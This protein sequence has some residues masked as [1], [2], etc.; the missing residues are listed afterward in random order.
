MQLNFTLWRPLVFLQAE[1]QAQLFYGA[2]FGL[3]AVMA[4]YNLFLFFAV[5]LR[6]YLFCALYM[7]GAMF[8]QLTY[9]G[10]STEYFGSNPAAWN[11]YGNLA[12]S[13]FTGFFALQFGK[14]FLQ[15]RSHAP[16]LNR[17]MTFLQAW[18]I[19]TMVLPFFIT[20]AFMSAYTAAMGSAMA[21]LSLVAGA[22]VYRLGNKPARYY[23]L[24]WG[25]LQSSVVVHVLGQFAVLPLESIVVRHALVIGSA[26]DV[27]LLSLA[28]A[29]QINVMRQEKEHAQ[30]IAL[31]AQRAHTDTL[32]HKVQER[33]AALE[34]SMQVMRNFYNFIAH[35]LRTPLTAI[36]AYLRFLDQGMRC[37]QP[38]PAQREHLEVLVRNSQ[39]MLH[40]THQLLDLARA[41]SGMRPPTLAAVPVKP[42]V[43][44]CLKQLLGLFAPEVSISLNIDATTEVLADEEHLD[45]IFLNLLSNAAKYTRSGNVQ[46]QATTEGHQVTVAVVDSGIGI[47]SSEVPELFKPFARLRGATRIEGTGLG[48]YIC[49]QLLLQMGGGLEVDS[50]EGVGTTVSVRLPMALAQ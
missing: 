17:L 43:D 14:T 5:R 31:D 13:G 6:V 32:E 2:Y 4:I 30:S 47:A 24:G 33:T 48:L 38:T 18:A 22:W 11:L 39:R 1:R 37:E 9:R 45:T 34:R 49:L 23:L 25:V 15:L 19:S 28:L 40:L 27:L 44:R 26:L 16:I 50:K 8:Q 20:R 36:K 10:F 42:I 29:D 35:E 41:E 21:T 12:F 7:L 46:I 3:I